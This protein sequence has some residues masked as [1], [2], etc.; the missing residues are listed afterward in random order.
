[1]A[2]SSVDLPLDDPSSPAEFLAF[3]PTEQDLENFA[4]DLG[5]CYEIEK[6]L[7]LWFLKRCM[8]CELPN[9]WIRERDEYDQLLYVNINDGSTSGKHPNLPRYRECFVD[10]IE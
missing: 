6:D 4:L 3:Q 2:V 1:M 8:C 5:I 9:G 10:H 7:Y